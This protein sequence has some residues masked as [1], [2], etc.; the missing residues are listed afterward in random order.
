[1]EMQRP[2]INI[3]I[4]HRGIRGCSTEN[5]VNESISY[6]PYV[7][8]GAAYRAVISLQFTKYFRQYYD[9]FYSEQRN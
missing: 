3:E 9:C 6:F 2:K 8:S 5:R 4:Y 7:E 1:M